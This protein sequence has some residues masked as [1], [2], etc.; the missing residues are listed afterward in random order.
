MCRLHNNNA[1]SS[2][3]ALD[4][5]R[6][7]KNVVPTA[8]D[9]TLFPNPNG[10]SG[11]FHGEETISIKVLDATRTISLNVADI[12][13]QSARV[14]RGRKSF[15]GTVQI[16][17]ETEVAKITFNGEIG[18]GK[19]KLHIRFTGTHNQQLRGWYKSTWEDAAGKEH[20]IVTTQH[21][22][23]EARKSFPCFDEPEFKATFKVR[24]VI[25]KGL[26]ALS[27]GRRLSE[28]SISTRKKIVDFARTPKMS[29]Y[30][31]C[32]IVGEFVSSEPVFV[33]GKEIR[34]WTVPG[35]EHLTSFA[36][37]CAAHGIEWFEWYFGVPYFGG[38]K[39]DHVAIPDF[40]AG[41]ME[42]TG[43]VTY[44]EEA[45]LCDEATASIDEKE[46]IAVTVLH[47]ESHFWFGDFV[48][49]FWWNGLWL[50]ES[51]ATFM[52]NLCLAAWKPEW[53]IWDSFGY[54]RSGALRI[55]G[56]KSTHPIEMPVN[57]PDEIDEL[58]DAISYNKGGSVL[59]M[60]HQFIGFEVFRQGISIYLK[61]HGLGNTETGDL[62]DALE[63]SC[64][65]NGLD[66]PVRKI[67]DAWVFTPGHPVVSVEQGDKPGTIKVSQQ[68][69]R[70]LGD[71][72]SGTTWPIPLIIKAKGSNGET[73]KQTI[74]FDTASAT[75]DIGEGFEWVKVNAGGSGVYRVRY[76]SD[77]ALKLTANV[78][79]N[80]SVIER[81]NLVNDAWACVRAGLTSS[82]DFLSLVPLFTGETDPNVFGLI[83]GGLGGLRRLLPEDKRQPLKDI[84]RAFVKPTFDSLGWVPVDGES[85]QTTQLRVSLFSTLGI[86]CED[87]EVK[88]KADEMF[89]SWLKDKTSID[90]N[91]LGAVVGNLTYFGDDARYNEFHRLYKT[92]K[93]PNEVNT[94]LYSLSGFRQEELLQRTLALS[95][96]DEV[97]VQDSPF[98]FASLLGNKYAQDF[99]W[100]YLRQNW[101]QIKQVFPTNMVP[102]VASSCGSLDTPERA[103]EV[104]EFFAS[105]EVKAGAMAVAQM[106]EQL[107]IAVRLRV[108]ETDRLMAYLHPAA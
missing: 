92:A 84:V 44:R 47:E 11:R 50:N 29:T 33:N 70:F 77:L 58:F 62:W 52:E 25:D 93:T 71:S 81:F 5:F 4:S 66:V 91:M 10:K 67:M 49:M 8:Y 23:T 83:L 30:L 13:I 17:K 86:T 39:I 61:K 60:I 15:T 41:A 24:I 3:I 35:K 88:A 2:H 107:D 75:I 78:Q 46:G 95:L 14:T 99:A 26:V 54:T 103:A 108:N 22:A 45:L 1:I 19:W 16:D 21:E 38:D 102:R 32:F 63:E 27:N 7:P 42:N 105:H 89:A 53:K 97:S 36:L 87:E 104:R 101:E 40:E 34:I 74:L 43:C 69:F 94:F 55:D 72:E 28:K 79:E 37:K 31:T 9:I 80:L 65:I 51:F 85:V 18:R 64:H 82:V 59:D 20:V 98:L 12:N 6:L 73:T 100:E 76:A 68:Q 106:L 56:L 48:T 96:S 90:P 57:H